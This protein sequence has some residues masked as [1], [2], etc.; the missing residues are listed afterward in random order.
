[1]GLNDPAQSQ[2]RVL[3]RANNG[4]HNV[5]EYEIVSNFYGNLQNVN[6]NFRLFDEAIYIDT[7][8]STPNILLHLANGQVLEA[9]ASKEMPFWFSEF[10][11]KAYKA[12]A[13]Y[14]KS[15]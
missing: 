9:I 3:E 2:L 6:K 8:Q 7:S 13:K 15:K 10:L 11:P 14:E 1:M 5:P 4:G 12:V